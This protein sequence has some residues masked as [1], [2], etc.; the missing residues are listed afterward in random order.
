MRPMLA[1]AMMLLGLSSAAPGPDYSAYLADYLTGAGGNPAPIEIKS[2]TQKADRLTVASLKSHNGADAVV[3]SAAD[4]DGILA[5]SADDNA[6]ITA[7]DN[8]VPNGEGNP[9]L[10]TDGGAAEGAEGAASHPSEVSLNDLCNALFSSALDNDLPIPFFANL[11]W[12]ESRLRD[13]A[14]S[15]KG[16]QGIAQFMPKTAAETGLDNP[17]DPLQAIPASARLLR[18]LRMQFGNLG[19]VAAAY[20]A[21]AHRVAEWLE[22][23]GSLPAETRGY[24]VRVTGLSIDDWRSMAVN[25]DALTF[26]QHLPCRSLPAF[27]SVEQAQ[28]EQVQLEQQKLEE[29]KF[30]QD[31]QA[32]AKLEEAAKA[33]SKP[34]GSDRHAAE[35]KA[36]RG[37]HDRH[38]ARRATPAGRPGKREVEH[39]AHTGRIKPTRA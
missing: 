24:V 6:A 5:P 33:A 20:N 8:A 15:R 13:D 27:A 30:E 1:F 19:F 38:E 10:N 18:E 31:K 3:A 12:Q 14:V 7:D 26:V 36:G 34:G 35:R 21:G 16:A 22:H 2:A 9:A 28:S 39:H 23:R 25:D 37:S 11:I 17:F 32:Q 4:M 29:L